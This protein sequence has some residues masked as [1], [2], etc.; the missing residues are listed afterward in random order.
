MQQKLRLTVGLKLMFVIFQIYIKKLLPDL[1]TAVV[2]FFTL[3][4]DWGHFSLY[5]PLSCVIQLCVYTICRR[6]YRKINQ[7]TNSS[8][9]ERE[10]IQ[11]QPKATPVDQRYNSKLLRIVH[12]TRPNSSPKPCMPKGKTK[13]FTVYI[14]KKYKLQKQLELVIKKTLSYMSSL[15]KKI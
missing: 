7:S 4:L 11:R 12:H 10:N 14:Y 6:L 5:Q 15:Y 3:L 13:Q 8:E 1:K 2:V 9:T